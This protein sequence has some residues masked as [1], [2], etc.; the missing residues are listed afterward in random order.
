MRKVGGERASK[1]KSEGDLDGM[2]YNTAIRASEIS[3]FCKHLLSESEDLA[4]M[5]ISQLIAK[6]Y[7]INSYLCG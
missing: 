3:T 1:G 4:A 7:L 5:S 2:N 6:L